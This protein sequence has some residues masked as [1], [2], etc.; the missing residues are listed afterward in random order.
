MVVVEYRIG[1]FL[2]AEIAIHALARPEGLRHDGARK[3]RAPVDFGH[4]LKF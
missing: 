2:K 4:Q 1:T 3:S